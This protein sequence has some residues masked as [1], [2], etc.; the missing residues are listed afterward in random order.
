MLA[1]HSKNGGKVPKNRIHIPE[2]LFLV[3]LRTKISVIT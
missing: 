1:A 2:I 3:S